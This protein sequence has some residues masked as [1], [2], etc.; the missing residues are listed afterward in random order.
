MLLSPMWLGFADVDQAVDASHSDPDRNSDIPNN[1]LRPETLS[2]ALTTGHRHCAADVGQ[3][4]H[5]DQGQRM[6]D[7]R[8]DVDVIDRANGVHGAHVAP[9][10]CQFPE[11][12]V[13][14]CNAVANNAPIARVRVRARDDPT[15]SV[16]W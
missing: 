16:R 12:A 7:N 8:P 11:A 15:G 5:V 10:H 9:D 3:P 1:C 2:T 4:E 14:C 13:L 6:A